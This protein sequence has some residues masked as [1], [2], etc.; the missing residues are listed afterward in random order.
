MICGNPRFFSM[1]I[2]ETRCGMTKWEVMEL[3]V[4][5]SVFLS[6]ELFASQ[7]GSS[8]SCCWSLGTPSLEYLEKPFLGGAVHTFV[9]FA[10]EICHSL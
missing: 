5:L 4:V 6:F 3:I 7:D 10:A 8:F 9:L 2:T 1:E